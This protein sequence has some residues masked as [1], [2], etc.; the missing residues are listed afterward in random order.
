MNE[1][2]RLLYL[3]FAFPPGLRALHPAINP[4]GNSFET[5]MAGALRGHFDF[6]SVGQLPFPIRELPARADPASG[7]AHDLLLVERA[8][9]LWHRALSLRR[10]KRQFRDWQKSGWQPDAVLAYNLSPVYNQFIR[11]LRRQRGRPKLILL[12]LDSAQLG[13]PLPRAKR[14]RYR[15]KPFVTPDDEMLGEFDACIGLSRGVEQY[16][17]A[18][19][20]PF[21]WMPG[22]CTPERAPKCAAAGDGPIRFCYFGALAAHAGVLEMT[23][24]FLK[25][26]GDS[27]LH[28]CGYGKLAERLT[29]IAAS[30]PRLKF[31]GLLPTPE[32]CLRLGQSCDVLVN[33]RPPGHGNE[34][35]V[36]SKLF[37]YALCERAIVAGKMSGVDE[38]LGPEAF[39]FD[40]D[41][42][43]ASL[44][45]ALE[46]AAAAPRAEL[47]RRGARISERVKTE[48]NWPR[49]AARMAEF[50][51]RVR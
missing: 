11:W 23:D 45:A 21:L 40:P 6:R 28:V 2:S 47:R 24:A 34:N 36:P 37:D 39:Y 4:A 29:A 13:R 50:I 15:L 33:A 26:P 51:Q 48:F 18:R 49:Q 31:H 16:A 14:L 38:V 12:L 17:A 46:L 43:D 35:N 7:V 20:L 27:E 10:L 5:Q 19:R 42:F 32:D 30:W 8:P 1:K 25:T 41:N 9:E 44:R 3:S 22:G